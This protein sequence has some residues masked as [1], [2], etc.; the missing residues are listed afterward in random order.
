M[1]LSSWHATH[2]SVV[3]HHCCWASPALGRLGQCAGPCG[4]ALTRLVVTK[5]FRFKKCLLDAIVHD[6]GP[7]LPWMWADPWRGE[8]D[9]RKRLGDRVWQCDTVVSL[10]V[11]IVSGGRSSV[12]QV[13]V[14]VSTGLNL[15]LDLNIYTYGCK[16]GSIYALIGLDRVGFVW[17]PE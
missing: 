12:F 11:V 7:G 16:T 4:R 15:D 9:G 5:T 10:V 8:C 14:W 1:R 13:R 6:A 17:I 3:F 2:P